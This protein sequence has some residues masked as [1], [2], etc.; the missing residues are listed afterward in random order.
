M[1]IER[2]WSV[3]KK[4]FNKWFIIVPILIV[5][6]IFSPVAVRAVAPIK[7]YKIPAGSM[8]PTLAVGDH[9]I[10]NK[11]EYK[12]K[13]PERLDIVVF[14]YPVDPSKDFIKRII[15]LPGDKIEIKKKAVYLNDVK[16]D[17][18]YAAKDDSIEPGEYLKPRDDLGPLV[19]PEGKLF[20]MGD[21]RDH[22]YDSRF[23]GFVDVDKLKGKALFIYFS[24]D[25]S[26][27]GRTLE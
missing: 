1:R 20:V 25:F 2:L 13:S 18:P 24:K 5:A 11:L 26:R 15:G 3:E 27:I 8:L 21:N 7:A 19:V 12:S 17:E 9:I 10:V 16:I 23:W 22:S 6:A 4:R 14:P